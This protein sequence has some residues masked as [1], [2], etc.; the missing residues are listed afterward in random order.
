MHV[1]VVE[2]PAKAKT[3]RGYLGAAYEV[4]ATQGHV[5]DLPAKE[6]S[7]DP[8]RDFAMVY[9]TRRGASRPLGAIAAAL[10]D[11][12]GLMLA[13][14]PD[15]EGEAIAWQVLTW[16][17]NT[18]VL[19][20]KTVRRV[21]FHEITA[22]AVREA[23]RRP[24]AIDMSLVRAQQAR[25]ALDYLVG[26]RLSSLLWRKLR[27]S[28]SAGRVQS[29]ALRLVCAREAEIEAFEPQEYW[30]I[31]AGVMTE[32]GGSFTARLG[33]LDGQPLER[34]ALDSAVV[35][36]EAA[37]RVRES[38]FHVAAVEH[39]EVRRDPVPPF[40]TATLQQEAS[41]QLGF[42]VRRTMQ[43]AQT[44]YEGVE[45]DGETAGLVTYM[46]TDSVALSKT[47]TAAVRQLVRRCFAPDYLPR[48][49]RV[50]RSRARNAQ[51]AHEAIRPTDLARTP[52]A[53]TGR[54]GADEARLYALIWRR[55]V[56]SQM[57]AARLDRVRVELASETGDVVLG[58]SR[59]HTRF[60]GFLRL[61]REGRDD[62]GA[63][64]ETGRTLPAMAEGER[65]FVTEVRSE[66]RSTRA[67]S[68]YTE[69]GLVRR[70]EELGIGRP[71]TYAS[72]VGVLRER[73]YVVLYNRRFVPTE[74][75]RVVTAFLEAYFEPWVA[76]G[77]T[78]EMEADLDRVA[79]GGMVWKEVLRGFWGEF[80]GALDGAGG[81][82]RATVHAAVE[83]AL[84]TY[85]FGASGAPRE[86]ACPSCA[87][88][89]LGLKLGR[90]GAF[91][92]C[93]RFPACRYRRPLAGDRAQPGAG[94][95]E[96]GL[97]GVDPDTGQPLTLR[98]GPYG[99]YVQR[100][101]DAGE[102]RAA[103]ASVPKGTAPHEVTP[104]V[105]RA[106]LAL[107][108]TV[109]VHPVSGEPILAG[110]GRY[111]SWLKHGPTYVSLP[112]DEDV[113]TVGLNRAVMLV[114]TKSA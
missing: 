76:Y 23:M 105:A 99:L 26:F 72:I 59:S 19:E 10:R 71:S 36:E 114:D 47:A 4:V 86:R 14:D 78:T 31:D 107:P 45:L 62:D 98:S 15:R 53:V 92:G 11:A 49:A 111:G 91:I 94:G 89:R 46:R 7:V 65:V 39:D 75:G 55:A 5:T 64:V 33:G 2:S 81:L 6:G 82:D 22:E 52:D 69:A 70:L 17:R 109:G 9:A 97:I 28:R 100:G 68:R 87:D 42:G 63:E 44:L 34:Q 3:V 37:R 110:I 56:A 96:P 48:R 54:L 50:F 16:L 51:E 79:A 12:E 61:Y 25:R 18:G 112:D 74:R 104:D 29:V 32:R 13:T 84:E 102:E 77:F 8:A 93:S 113:L 85:L 108:R 20:G 67:P 24:R 41:R 101:E 30:T 83:R 88:G 103:R 1:V 95:H 90:Y 80:E 21:V 38:V 58:A 66:R 40:T 43:L 27:G 106:L 57:A 73:G 35:A 60:D